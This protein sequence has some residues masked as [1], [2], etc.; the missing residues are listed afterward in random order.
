[1]K[2][3]KTL[4]IAVAVIFGAAAAILGTA[5]WQASSILA[6]LQAGDKANVVRAV[7]PELN[8]KPARTLVAPPLDTHA[9]TILLI[10]SDHRWTGQNGARS[11]T[12]I[13]VRVDPSR[14]R[15]A[16]L[17]I[18]RDLY[19]AIPG[20]GHDRINEAFAR[21]GERLLTRVVRDTF[22]VEIDHFVELDFRGFRQLVSHLGGL[23]LPVDQ[24]Y[25]NKNVGT[26]ATNYADVD[27]QPGY[28]KLSGAQALAFA[29][30]RH[31]D[32]DVY[33]AARQQLVIREA[34]RQALADKLDLLRIRRLAQDFA[35]ATTSDISSF[36]EVWSLASAAQSARVQRLTVEAADVVYYGAD[37]LQASD[38]QLKETV[39]RWL[40][41]RPAPA[42]A[43]TTAA[44]PAAP[45]ALLPDGGRASALL[46]P[47]VRGMRRCV[48]TELPSGYWWPDG[49][50][51]AYALDGHPA[52]ALYATAG[53]GRSLL[54]SFTTWQD[55][56]ILRGP[57]S[58]RLLGG[59][60]VELW[61][62]SGSLRQVAWRDGPTR[63]WLTNTLR[64]ELGARQL[65]A[66]VKGCLP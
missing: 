2:S 8:R 54:W 19:V 55:P 52:I 61:S 35:R 21:G 28:Q 23:W 62:D 56:P 48:P 30:Y 64:N 49:A 44:A 59:R 5:W 39:A 6:E 17:S 46:E 60:Q 24:R 45:V 4:A 50:A 37:Y 58:T 32:S 38:A 42:A 65:L 22:G 33:R 14:S 13:L 3:R 41:V 40:G 57:S 1:V 63:V 36:G 7:S 20:H 16:L 43:A 31:G 27:L 29:R 15:V 34:L 53:S 47:L 18:P 25:F 66:L 10:G 11:D 51:R 12:V 26:A 9:Q